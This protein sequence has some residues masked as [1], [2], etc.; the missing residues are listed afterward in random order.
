M[1][2]PKDELLK[3]C[4][5]PELIEKHIIQA[6]RV[7][8]TWQSTWSP[9][10]SAPVREEVLRI[11]RP[12]NNL[13]WQSEGGYPDAERQRLLCIRYQEEIEIPTEPVPIKGIHIE[14]NFLFDRVHPQD[15]RQSLEM[16]GLA[17]GE[18]GDIWTRGDRG[19]QVLCTPKA[20]EALNGCTTRVRDV[21]IK[22][23]AVE[24]NQ[25]QLP[26]QRIPKKFTTVE[27]STRLDA[28]AS[29]GFGLS[30]AKVVNQ[31]KEGKVRLNWI[32]T[33]QSNKDLSVGD[34]IQLEQKGTLEIKSIE[35]TNRKRWRIEL[36]RH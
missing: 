30:R 15:F 8:K 19:A 2:L 28:I 25:L 36:L 14:G 20:A 34:R 22:C 9:F 24:K 16:I 26:V 3:G 7:L 23:E 4:K 11:M 35:L 10:V 13:H 17:S 21:K 1:K 6:E 32:L 27:A 33:K 31:I 12:L 29:A 18:I 5:Y